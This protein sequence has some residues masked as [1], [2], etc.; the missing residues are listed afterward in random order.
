MNYKE[1]FFI[2]SGQFVMEGFLNLKWSRWK[3]ILL[4]R[5]LAIAPTFAVTL[6]S[7]ISQLTGMNDYMNALMSLQLPFAL[8]P[9]LTF[10]SSCY[11][12]GDFANGLTN[13][14]IASV[15][16]IAVIFINIYFVVNLVINEFAENLLVYILIA[17]FGAYYILFI[18][19]LV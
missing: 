3:R 11:V 16:S 7:S 19:Y 14:I 15:L 2:K 4:T 17:I 1:I 18:V 9:T 12:M 8:L 5:T 6:S 10:T 13:K